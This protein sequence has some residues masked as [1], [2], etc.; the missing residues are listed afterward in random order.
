MYIL[1]PENQHRTPNLDMA[2]NAVLLLHSSAKYEDRV[3]LTSHLYMRM[4]KAM[5]LSLLGVV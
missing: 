4:V 1:T 5:H 2:Y 3:L